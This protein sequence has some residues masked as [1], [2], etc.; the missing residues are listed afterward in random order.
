ML[1]IPTVA[2]V[3]GKMLHVNIPTVAQVYVKMLHVNIQTVA[4]VYVKMLHVK[5]PTVAQ[6]YVKM[7]HVNIDLPQNLSDTK[8]RICADTA[9]QILVVPHC[10]ITSALSSINM[11]GFL[12]F[13]INSEQI[14]RRLTV[15]TFRCLLSI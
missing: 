13:I 14:L 6:V 12:L 7:L 4:Q 2:Q 15:G 5:M 3:Y 1:H 10:W 11:P 9:T 8:A